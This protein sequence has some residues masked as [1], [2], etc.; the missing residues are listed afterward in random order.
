MKKHINTLLSCIIFI[1]CLTFFSGCML[2]IS[3]RLMAENKKIPL[4]HGGPHIGVFDTNDIVFEYSYTKKDNLM[5]ISGNL[6]FA[7]AITNDSYL[8]YFSLSIYLADK[9]GK[10]I[11]SRSFY[12][13][14]RGKEIDTWKVR[15]TIGIPKGA[16]YFA[17]GYSGQTMEVGGESGSLIMGGSNSYGWDFWQ[18][19]Y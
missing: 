18:V 7:G 2:G 14:G 8:N 5:K 1:V 17:F 12:N 3:G 11:S 16:E 13:L 15:R 19:P 4:K 10:I 6:E 9:D